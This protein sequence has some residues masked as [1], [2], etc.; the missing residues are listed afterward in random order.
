MS[1][2]SVGSGGSSCYSPSKSGFL[3]QSDEVL[4]RSR[5]GV[6]RQ[7]EEAIKKSNRRDRELVEDY[8]EGK[9]LRMSLQRKMVARR[10][11]QRELLESKAGQ[12]E[13]SFYQ[14]ACDFYVGTF[15]CVELVIKEARNIEM[16]SSNGSDSLCKVN[17]G[18]NDPRFTQVCWSTLNPSWNET[19]A[20]VLNKPTDRCDNIRVE[21]F[22]QDGGQ[23][24]DSLGAFLGQTNVRVEELESERVVDI[25]V[26]LQKASTGSLFMSVK[27]VP[28]ERLI[29]EKAKELKNE[30]A[31][32]GRRAK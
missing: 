1:S 23:E 16:A 21:V 8:N 14:K 9:T 2:Q 7:A 30:S 6:R 32:R 18:A 3:S 5:G 20:F 10:T 27:Y 22:D 15:G 29:E 25:A 13:E 12:R 24:R 17:F 28:L 31:L 4:S 26:E 19:F 11:A